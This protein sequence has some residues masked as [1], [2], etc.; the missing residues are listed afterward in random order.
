MFDFRPAGAFPISDLT[1]PSRHGRFGEAGQ[2]PIDAAESGISIAIGGHRLRFEIG[3]A[4]VVEA[5]PL[6]AEIALEGRARGVMPAPLT[7]SARVEL[8]AGSATARIAITIRNPRRAQ[9]PGGVWVLGD[10]GSIHLH[11]AVLSLTLASAIQ[12]LDFAAEAGDPMTAGTT[13]FEI[14]QESSGGEHW[15]GPVHRNQ[16]GTVPWRMRGY[17]R[18]VGHGRRHRASRDADRAARD[19]RRAHR[20]RRAALLGELSERDSRRRHERRDRTLPRAGTGAGRA[21]GRRAEDA[22]DRDRL[23]RRHGVRPAARW[24][25]TRCCSFRRRRGARRRARCRISRRAIANPTAGTSRSSISRSIAAGF[26]AKREQAD[27]YGWRHFGDIY[28]DHESA[29][30]AARRSRSCRT[31]TISTTPSPASRSS[32][33]AAATRAGGG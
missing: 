5:G 28:A 12:R 8:F 29:F 31:T 24:V 20:D 25:P 17:R 4:R 30:A 9:H 6:R 32:S 10:R 1:L 3:E 15:N 11:A 33:C 21:A 23:R 27:E 16:H 2:E 7:V 26:L 14:V 18:P 19:R 22:H 13:P